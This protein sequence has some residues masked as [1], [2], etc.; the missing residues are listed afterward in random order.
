ML[1]FLAFLEKFDLLD[2]SGRQAVMNEARRLVAL[3]HTH[4]GPADGLE[5]IVPT[6][7]EDPQP[8]P[9]YSDRV[10]YT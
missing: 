8:L 5:A 6:K 7:Q 1:Q 2:Q 3:Q 9:S 10:V 4:S